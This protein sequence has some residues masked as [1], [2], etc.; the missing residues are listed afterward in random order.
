MKKCQTDHHRLIKYTSGYTPSMRMT[1]SRSDT[2]MAS[3][4]ST[5][6]EHDQI[7]ESVWFVGENF[8]SHW[9][10]ILVAVWA[11]LLSM[12]FTR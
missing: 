7:D 11:F 9:S 1:P 3:S 10:P 8:T 4:P 2:T 6:K 5:L 12:I